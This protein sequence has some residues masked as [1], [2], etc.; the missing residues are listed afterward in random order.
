MSADSNQSLGHTRLQ[1]AAGRAES[2]QTSLHWRKLHKL[3][4][5]CRM[6][7]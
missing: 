2:D 4:A 5:D 7:A 6:Q 1:E 3:G